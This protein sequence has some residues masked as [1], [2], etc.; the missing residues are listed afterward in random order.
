LF[1]GPGTWKDVQSL[2]PGL[3]IDAAAHAAML[4]LNHGAPGIYNIADDDGAVSIEKARRA[5]GFDPA[6]RI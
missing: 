5:L 2:K 3:H 4:A 1:Y 6:F